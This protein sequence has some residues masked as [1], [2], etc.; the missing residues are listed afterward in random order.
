VN[1]NAN[2]LVPTNPFADKAL[3][4]KSLLA[5][6]GLETFKRRVASLRTPARANLDGI[7]CLPPHIVCGEIGH[8]VV[9]TLVDN[10]VVVIDRKA[11]A[12]LKGWVSVVTTQRSWRTLSVRSSRL[13]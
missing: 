4:A 8:A 11:R 2:L 9:R 7:V 13:S 10:V 5:V 3:T 12:G 6:E 1:E